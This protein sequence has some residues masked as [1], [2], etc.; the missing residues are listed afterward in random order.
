MIW[1]WR[2]ITHFFQAQNMIH[3]QNINWFY[4]S[5]LDQMEH[6]SAVFL[7]Y[8]QFFLFIFS[9]ISFLLN[10]TKCDD[11][12]D[13]DDDNNNRRSTLPPCIAFV[14]TVL[15]VEHIGTGEKKKRQKL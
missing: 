4:N 6:L 2:D 7:P 5:A 10:G 14:F 12:N 15:S 9:F 8:F 13:D 11:E 1:M 3:E